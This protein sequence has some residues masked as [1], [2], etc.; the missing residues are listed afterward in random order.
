MGCLKY[1]DFMRVHC[2]NPALLFVFSQLEK[3]APCL[4]FA[5]TAKLQGARLSSIARQRESAKY[6]SGY[7]ISRQPAGE[8]SVPA[9]EFAIALLPGVDAV[10]LGR[11]QVTRNIM[12]SGHVRRGGAVAARKTKS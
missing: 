4:F 3:C 2:R 12:L 5:C 6:C 9:Q 1:I 7:N 11:W 8:A 10:T